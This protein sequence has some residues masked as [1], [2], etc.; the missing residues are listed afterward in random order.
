MI[1]FV[2]NFKTY[3]IQENY[4]DCGHMFG[5]NNFIKDWQIYATYMV[6]NLRADRDISIYVMLC[7]F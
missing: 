7:M 3:I 4:I 6:I 1:H 2:K 5:L